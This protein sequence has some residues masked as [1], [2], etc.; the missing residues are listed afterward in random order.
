MRDDVPLARA[1]VFSH[2][3]QLTRLREA[4][5]AALPVAHVAGDPCFDRILAS[6]TFRRRYRHALGVGDR[7]LVLLSTTWSRK[8]T[9][10]V[11]FD[12]VRS[13]LAELPRDEYAVAIVVHPNVTHRHGVSQ[14]GLWFADCLRAGLI[15]LD[16]IDGWRPGLI[17]A[18]VVIGDNGSVTGYAAALG[19]PTLLAAFPDVPPHTAISELGAAAGRLPAHGPYRAVID[20]ARADDATDRFARVAALMTS[21]PRRSLTLLRDIFY[22]ILELPVPDSEVRDSILPAPVSRPVPDTFADIVSV[23]VEAAV[24]RIR[25][26]P[27]EIQTRA[28]FPTW[29]LCCATD[30][31]IRSLRENAAVLVGRSGDTGGDFV[32]WSRTQLLHNPLAV[33][34]A[35]ET[36]RGCVAMTREGVAVQVTGCPAEIA[37]SMLYAW[38]ETNSDHWPGTHEVVVGNVGYEMDVERLS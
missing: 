33:V 2:T 35:T 9:I 24:I 29:H 23:T 17:A 31:P 5:P 3:N 12:L 8:S 10:G 18:D 16:E 27:A 21:E 36:A 11:R 32:R 28:N 37:A 7:T 6:R 13:L 38:R 4:T 1:L 19:T 22:R 20:E 26:R 34:V 30:Y 25:R 15:V 14:V